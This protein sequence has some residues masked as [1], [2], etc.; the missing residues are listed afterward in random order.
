M[1]WQV[2]KQPNGKYCIWSSIVDDFIVY[3]ATEKEII[4]YWV[5]DAVTA[6]NVA[7][8]AQIKDANDG[9]IRKP[10]GLDF[11]G[12]IKQLEAIHGIERAEWF[13]TALDTED[14]KK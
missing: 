6:A 14:M 11:D 12:A 10:F 2:I 8:I 3:E 5:K 13:M 9:V 7:A 4:D 1:G